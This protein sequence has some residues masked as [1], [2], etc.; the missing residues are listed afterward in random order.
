MNILDFETIMLPL[1]KFAEDGKE[2]SIDSVEKYLSKCFDLTD[3]ERKMP[4]LS[5]S[6]PLFLNRL[7]WARLFLK[8]AGLVTDPRRS[9]YQITKNRKQALLTN[10]SNINI[11]FLKQYPLFTKWY[12]RKK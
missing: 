3:D 7:R 9:Y 10:P 1:L 6:E 12:S 4:K 11:S 5:G 8:K 2:H